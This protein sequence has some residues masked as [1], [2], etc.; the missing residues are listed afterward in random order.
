M[1]CVRPQSLLFQIPQCMTARTLL[2]MLEFIR[3]S[4]HQLG[5]ARVFLII[6]AR[7][8][9]PSS[10]APELTGYT[11]FSVSVISAYGVIVVLVVQTVT[12]QCL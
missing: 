12:P 11:D 5:V 3:L 9:L 6:I 8:T 10:S 4:R 1:V 2:S 7:N